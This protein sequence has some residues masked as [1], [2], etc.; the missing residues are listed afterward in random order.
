MD[1]VGDEGEVGRFE[2]FLAFVLAF[3]FGMR[4]GGRRERDE[5]GEAGGAMV[6]GFHGVED[7]SKTCGA[8]CKGRETGLVGGS[9]MAERDAN[10][11]GLG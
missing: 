3:S 7:V 2:W 6:E 5:A 11:L 9:G 1:A 10:V 4:V 8:C